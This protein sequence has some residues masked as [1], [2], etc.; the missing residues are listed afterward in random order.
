[1]SLRASVGST[2]ASNGRLA[3]VGRIDRRTFRPRS[4]LDA[5]LYPCHARLVNGYVGCGIKTAA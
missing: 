1:M 3:R 4:R 5:I 2:E